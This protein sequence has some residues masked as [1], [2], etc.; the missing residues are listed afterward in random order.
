MRIRIARGVSPILL[1]GL[2]G[3]ILP[4]E[5]RAQN[6]SEVPEATRDFYQEM[7]DR[8]GATL[9]LGR[10]VRSSRAYRGQ[11][12]T[13]VSFKVDGPG[14]E[15]NGD[16]ATWATFG[17]MPTLSNPV[18]SLAVRGL[19]HQLS[20]YGTGGNAEV[21]NPDYPGVEES[22]N[23]VRAAADEAPSMAPRE[24]RRRGYQG[25]YDPNGPDRDCGDFRTHSAAQAFFEAA[26]G[27]ARD[28]H[29]LDGDNDG[30]ACEGLP[31]V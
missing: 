25:R 11:A 22:Q 17:D 27:P 18:M 28:P 10:A 7:L 26:G 29:R 1:L 30:V 8:D 19:A 9:R 21:K 5:V 24:P 3:L 13:F 12:V 2:A 15:G 23:C 31:G 14:L 16:I 4:G 6:C 20:L